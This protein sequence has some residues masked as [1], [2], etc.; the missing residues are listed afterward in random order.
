MTSYRIIVSDAR[1]GAWIDAYAVTAGRNPLWAFAML[2]RWVR[3]YAEFLAS[4]PPVDW[5]DGS[6]NDL[7]WTAEIWE[8]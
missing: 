5:F 4:N 2:K 1:T 7:V 6:V 8:R 3:G